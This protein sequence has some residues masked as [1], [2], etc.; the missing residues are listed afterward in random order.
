MY[1]RI[2]HAM[3]RDAPP[4]PLPLVD[5]PTT[6]D[7]DPPSPPHHSPTTIDYPDN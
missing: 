6:R 1:L 2:E 7:F 3:E 4:T 5:P